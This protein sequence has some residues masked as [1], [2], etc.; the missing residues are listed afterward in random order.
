[1]F[2]N[3]NQFLF[4]AL[5]MKDATKIES[6]TRIHFTK[7]CQAAGVKCTRQRII[8]YSEIIQNLTHPDAETVYKNVR[9]QL[10]K[11]SLDTV[12]R[13]LWLFKDLGLITTMGPSRERTRFDPNSRPHHHFTCTKCGSILDFNSEVMDRLDIQDAIKGIGKFR[14]V[15]INVQGV[16]LDC[17]IKDK[18]K[19]NQ[20]NKG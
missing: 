18:T 14:S 9:T 1:M 10:P 5:T 2:F 4:V 20:E 11:I 16:C 6:K 7:I 12:Y 8:V 15:E 19:L 13:T 17:A 3:R